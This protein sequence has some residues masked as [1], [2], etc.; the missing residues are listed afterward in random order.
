MIDRI[1]PRIAMA[2]TLAVQTAG[3]SVLAT[4]TAAPAVLAACTA[5]G[6]GVGNLITLPSLILRREVPIGAFTAAVGLA[7]AGSQVAYAFA[8]LSVGL[9]RDLFGDYSAAWRLCAGLDMA[10]MIMI[11]PGV[12]RR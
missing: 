10:A 8:P 1:D 9:F 5:Y 6:L 3:L 7:M 11:L 2:V 4:T 12:R